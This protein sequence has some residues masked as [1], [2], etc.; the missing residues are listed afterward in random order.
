MKRYLFILALVT[1]VL[2]SCSKV[3]RNEKKYVEAMRSDDYQAAS[4]AFDE[5]CNWMVSDKATMTH[6][7]KLMREKM[8]L[9]IAASKDGRLRCYS[10]PTSAGKDVKVYANIVQWMV[11][12]HFVGFT[13]PVDKLLAGRSGNIKKRGTMAHLIDTIYQIDNTEPTVYIIEQSY[14]NVDGKNRAYVSAACIDGLVLRLLPFFFDGIEIAGNYEFNP[15]GK[16]ST[17]DL[18]KWDEQTGRFYAYQTDDNYNVIPGRYTVY[19]LDKDRF[20]RLPDN[21]D[22]QN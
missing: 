16:I 7:F 6:D 13:G 21:P 22:N 20:K 9:T 4:Q 1:L 8:G 5:Y 17:S 15:G 19:Q 10:L 12:G 2:A 18:F 11:D 3:E 14:T